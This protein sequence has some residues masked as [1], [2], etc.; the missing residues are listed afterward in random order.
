MS[1][2]RTDALGW[3]LLVLGAAC[4]TAHDL[5]QRAAMAALRATVTEEMRAQVDAYRSQIYAEAVAETLHAIRDRGV[6]LWSE[7]TSTSRRG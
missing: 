1:K 3:A 6:P 4:L 2:C 7:K 5:R